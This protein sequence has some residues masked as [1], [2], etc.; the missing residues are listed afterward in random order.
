MSKEQYYNKI[1]KFV[2]R[3]FDELE[4]SKRNLGNDIFL[5]YNNAKY[6]QILIQKKSGYIYYQS[7]YRDKIIKPI[8]LENVDFE[9]LLKRWVEDTFQ[10]KVNDTGL[11]YMSNATELKK[12][13]K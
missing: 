10:M 9:I 8:A 13:P 3:K 12:P 6:D 4:V 1:K 2:Y 11:K 5:H 7:K